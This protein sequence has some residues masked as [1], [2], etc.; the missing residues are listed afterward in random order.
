MCYNSRILFTRK[1]TTKVN[2]QWMDD[3][4]VYMSEVI[5]FIFFFQ[6]HFV[7]VV[8]FYQLRSQLRIRKF[9]VFCQ[10]RTG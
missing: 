1:I 8:V 9:V 2:V 7:V 4:A 6:L 10:I 3:I 5:S